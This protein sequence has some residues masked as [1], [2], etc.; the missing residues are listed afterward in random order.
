[1]HQPRPQGSTATASW[2]QT[3]Q[4]PGEGSSAGW[5]SATQIRRGRGLAVGFW[6]AVAMASPARLPSTLGRPTQREARPAP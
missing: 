5:G 3:P 1:M 6:R 4:S 2:P